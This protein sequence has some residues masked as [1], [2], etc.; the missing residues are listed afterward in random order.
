MNKLSI[1]PLVPISHISSDAMS[2]LVRMSPLF[3]ASHAAWTM[4]KAGVGEG[5]DAKFGILLMPITEVQR[6]GLKHATTIYNVQP[7][8]ELYK[9]SLDIIEK[10]RQ[11]LTTI[12]GVLPQTDEKII[13]KADIEMARLLGD[14]QLAQLST[15][16]IIDQIGG[17]EHV[18]AIG[19]DADDFVGLFKGNALTKG[20]VRKLMQI[21]SQTS[22]YTGGTATETEAPAVPAE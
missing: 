5:D 1:S 15:V 19:P 22:E 3:A 6:R 2:T 17:A 13:V 8:T 10:A 21:E 9:H 11:V 7:F 20:D 18:I 4:A 14:S 12:A 16:I